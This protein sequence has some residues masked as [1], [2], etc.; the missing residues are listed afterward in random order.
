MADREARVGVL[1]VNLGTPESPGVRDVRRYLREFL[2]DPRVLDVNPVLHTLLLYGTILPFRPR[3]AAAAYAKIWSEQGS[4]L[5]VHGRALA[6]GVAKALGPRF[7]VELAMRY[8]S[9][10]MASALERLCEADSE[11]VIVLPLFPQYA[12]SS[13]GSSLERVYSLAGARWNASALSVVPPF[14]DRPEFRDALAARSR[15]V[16]DAFQP[17]HVLFSYH[18]L[19]ER[20][21]RRSDGSGGHCLARA[22]CCAAIGASNRHC[23]RAQCFATSRALQSALGLDASA[24]GTS[25]QSRMAGTPWIR[26]FTDHVLPELAQRGVRRLAVLCPSFVADCLE[27]VEEVGIRAVE[28]WRE[29]GG[30]A[31]ELVP[32]LNAEPQWIEALAGWIREHAGA[33][34]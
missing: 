30:E 13:T 16:L 12:G 20:Q 3:R 14:Y 27:T 7:R 18:G 11:R 17:D 32:C 19:P 23:Y 10:D 29:L 24:C 21:V 28:Q 2:S 15:P 5:L 33:S 34:A 4:P 9:P 26:P 31:L 6:E 25:F 22:D 1:L 8:G